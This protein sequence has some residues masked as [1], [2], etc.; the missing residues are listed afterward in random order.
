MVLYVVQRYPVDGFIPYVQMGG[1]FCYP[2]LARGPDGGL[3]RGQLNSPCLIGCVHGLRSG[4]A[5]NDLL[6][7]VHRVM[8]M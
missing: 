7:L 8:G 6:G 4:Q 2:R 5:R 3:A 1:S